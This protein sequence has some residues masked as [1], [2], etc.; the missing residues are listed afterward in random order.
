MLRN[1]K[2]KPESERNDLQYVSD[3]G[4]VSK[5]YEYKELLDFNI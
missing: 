4:A 2:A 1:W 5:L 3:K